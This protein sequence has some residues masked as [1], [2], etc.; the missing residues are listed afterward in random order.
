[1]RAGLGIG[2][3]STRLGKGDRSFALSVE[4]LD[5]RSGEVVCV[6]GASG[7]GKT[8]FL[9]LLSLLR[10]PSGGSGYIWTDARG[11]QTDLVGLWQGGARGTALARTRGQ[12]FGFVPQTGALVPYLSVRANVALT[13]DITGRRD[14]NRVEAL[15]DRLGLGALAD[16]SPGA[17]SIGQRQRV[18]IARALAHFPAFVIADEPTA[19]L[20]PEAADT[21][22][23]LLL[24]MAREEG[25][26]VILSSHDLARIGGQGLRRLQ[27]AACSAG[28]GQVAATAREVPC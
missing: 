28:P 10:A 8:L 20:D 27:F 13:Q 9:E 1:M 11:R 26:G 4:G 14:R 22:M 21:V 23:Q 16:L 3:L 2:R 7:T 12:L 25:V 5:L 6:T 19:A 18:S 15:L 17:L 24:S